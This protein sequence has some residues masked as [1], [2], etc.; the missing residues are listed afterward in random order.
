VTTKNYEKKCARLV[1]EACSVAYSTAL[2]WV[3]E[4]EAM[5]PE[6]MQ[7][8]TR[9]LAIVDSRHAAAPLPVPS[10][11]EQTAAVAAVEAE[12]PSK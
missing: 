2:R 4:H 7:D 10:P 6:A 3:R 5:H 9:A 1:Q 12:F 8:R 11:T